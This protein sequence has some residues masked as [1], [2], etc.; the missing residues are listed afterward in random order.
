MIIE[1]LFKCSKC[2]HDRLEDNL[3]NNEI[4]RMIN[5]FVPKKC[6]LLRDYL[7]EHFKRG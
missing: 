3:P 1:D 4:E 5:L 2:G 6:L 7:I